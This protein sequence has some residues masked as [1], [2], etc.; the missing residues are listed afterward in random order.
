MEDIRSIVKYETDSEKFLG[1][2]AGNTTTKTFDEVLKYA[3]YQSTINS[4]TFF[5]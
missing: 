2:G 5:W 3:G 1:Y 4:Q